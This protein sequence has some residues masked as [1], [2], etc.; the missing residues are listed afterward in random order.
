MSTWLYLQCLDHDPPITS[1]DEVGQHLYNLADIRR[2]VANRE[3]LYNAHAAGLTGGDYNVGCGRFTDN[4]RAFLL[5]HPRCNLR[6]VDEY[7]QEHPIEDD[8]EGEE[9][10]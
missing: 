9:G 4:A 7:G 1:A 10:K 8:R 3:L 2:E 6:I 5:Q